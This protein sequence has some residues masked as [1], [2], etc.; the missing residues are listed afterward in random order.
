MA[1]LVGTTNTRPAA[2]DDILYAYLTADAYT[3]TYGEDDDDVIAYPIW[4]GTK[5][6]T[7]YQEYD[8]QTLMKAG[9]AISY[10]MDG[11]YAIDVAANGTLAAI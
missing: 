11:D 10:K 1:V 6:D 5:E 8:G 3:T 9:A 4:N 2:H 7:I